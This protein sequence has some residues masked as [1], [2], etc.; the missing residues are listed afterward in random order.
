MKFIKISQQNK[1]DFFLI[2]LAN[3]DYVAVNQK[4]GSCMIHLS[5]GKTITCMPYQGGQLLTQISEYN[6]QL[7]EYFVPNEP[8]EDNF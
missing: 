2:N 5:S 7:L 1:K 8:V 6:R 4:A 3:I